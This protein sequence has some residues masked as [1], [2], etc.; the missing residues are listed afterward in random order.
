MHV[1]R[2]GIAAQP[3]FEVCESP[4]AYVGREDVRFGET[5]S[6]DE[7][8]ASGSGAAIPDF[9]GVWFGRYC[10][11]GH[12]AGTIVHVRKLLRGIGAAVAE[13]C[14]FCRLLLVGLADL[15]CGFASVGVGP[16]LD[17]PAGMG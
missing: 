16:T 12:E 14:A 9:L 3:C 6:E 15:Q 7:G 4:C 8:L 1:G 2:I 17:E 11:F 13:H 10:E 5:E